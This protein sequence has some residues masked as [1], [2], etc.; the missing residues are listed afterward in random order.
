MT[1][2]RQFSAWLV[3]HGHVVLPQPTETFDVLLVVERC[4]LSYAREAR[5]AKRPV[6]LRMDGV[7]HPALPGLNGYLYPLRNWRL[8]QL[9]NH[10]ADYVIYQSEFSRESCERFLGKATAPWSLIYNGVTILPKAPAMK[11]LGSRP[12]RLVSAASFRRPD[13][14]EPL[15]ALVQHLARPYEL[16]LIGPMTPALRSRLGSRLVQPRVTWHGPL[17]HGQLQERLR[18]FDIFLFSD[19]SACPHSVLEALGAGRPVVGFDRGSMRELVATGVS[20]EVVPLASHDPFQEQNPFTA[21]ALREAAA[22][23]E[24][25]AADLAGYQQR[26]WQEARRRFSYDD[27]AEA[28]LSV[29]R[30]LL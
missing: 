15:L 17:A 5:A 23:V 12:V 27:I 25:V 6:V 24:R 21:E 7:H 29:F 13:Q 14:V 9:H 2:V 19:Q 8:R 3:A 20:G 10:L 16:H 22:A 18:D 4:P 11:A 1:F 30:D 28:Y 26:A